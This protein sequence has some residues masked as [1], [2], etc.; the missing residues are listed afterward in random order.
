MNQEKYD[1]LDEL[2]FEE[3]ENLSGGF[4]VKTY[5]IISIILS[6]IIPNI[7]IKNSIYHTSK[8]ILS[9]RV[10]HRSL[11]EESEILTQKLNGIKFKNRIMDSILYEEMMKESE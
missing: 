6:L 5:L 9:L 11:I 3:N 8:S 10:Q 1:L 4:L 7:Y 2:H